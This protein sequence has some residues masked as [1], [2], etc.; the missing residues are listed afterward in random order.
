MSSS[1]R[2]KRTSR[3]ESPRINDRP[4]LVCHGLLTWTLGEQEARAN[5]RLRHKLVILESVRK[6]PPRLLLKQESATVHQHQHQYQHQH[7]PRP[8]K[9]EVV[10]ENVPRAGQERGNYFTKFLAGQFGLNSE[11]RPEGWAAAKINRAMRRYYRVHLLL[12][13]RDEQHLALQSKLL[14]E[15]CCRC[16]PLLLGPTRTESGVLRLAEPNLPKILRILKNQANDGLDLLQ[17]HGLAQ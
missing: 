13:K 9:E 2:T 7:A 3:C 11:E 1:T 4:I 12:T 8:K 5:K 16:R 17:P 15:E 6:R 14:F 10:S